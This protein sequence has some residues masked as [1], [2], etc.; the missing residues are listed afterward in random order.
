[1][2]NELLQNARSLY[3]A[4][5]SLGVDPVLVLHLPADSHQVGFDNFVL[6][7]VQTLLR[8]IDLLA[9]CDDGCRDG[10]PAPAS[11]GHFQAQH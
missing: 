8:N 7:A 2:E 6:D 3:L 4:L 1:M 9:A 10:A 5:A 11:N